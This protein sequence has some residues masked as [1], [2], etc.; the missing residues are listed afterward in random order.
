MAPLAEPGQNE[1]GPPHQSLP[2]LFVRFLW[3]GALAWGGPVAQIGM[4]GSSL[5]D[6]QHWIS[7][8]RFNRTLAVYQVLPGPEAQELAVFFGMV[9]RGRIG[10]L[11][12]GLGFML[13]GFVLMLA[14]SWLY[15]ASGLESPVAAA[16]F[17]GCQAAVVALVLRGLHRIGERVLGSPL[18]YVVAIL[19]VGAGLAGVPFVIPLAVGGLVFL[20]NERGHS[21]MAGAPLLLLAVAM[22]LAIVANPGASRRAEP[23]AGSGV[24]ATPGQLLVTGLKGGALTF[25][26]AYTSIPFVRN[27]AVG[28]DGWMSDGQFLDGLALAGII[29]APLVIFATFVGFVGGGIV[30]ATAITLGMFLP[31]FAIT[32]LGHGL[33]ERVVND[34]RLHAL[35]DGITAAVIGL[36]AATALQLAVAALTNLPT[37]L[38]FGSALA[39][40]YLWRAGPA[41]PVIILGAAAIGVVLLR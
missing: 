7:L 22:V 33:L 24:E 4:L 12:A 31:A 10:G 16:A 13:P 8:P 5:V 34:Q 14:L 27:D 41:G 21:R 35:L 20:L 18:S 25:G 26:G 9:A 11:L 32:M 38:I 17:A 19:S 30:G 40:L 1:A 3:F 2:S 15:V 28:P 6:E 36:V 29:P 39:A 23:P 37:V